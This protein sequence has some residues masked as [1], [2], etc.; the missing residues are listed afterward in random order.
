MWSVE[1]TLSEVT[2]KLNEC[3]THKS[4]PRCRGGDSSEAVR[5]CPDTGDFLL[6]FVN[7]LRS[8]ELSLADKLISGEKRVRVDRGETHQI[9]SICN[10]LGLI[11]APRG[12]RSRWQHVCLIYQIKGIL[13][14]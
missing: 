10:Y 2:V 1:Q 6:H 4:P 3:L 12:V 7:F 14:R 5:Q 8:P 13:V 11:A 9:F